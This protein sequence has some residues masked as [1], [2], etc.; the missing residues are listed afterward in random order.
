[1]FSFNKFKFKKTGQAPAAPSFG[2]KV[3]NVW[4]NPK[5]LEV[6]LI[7][8]G[9]RTE[10]DWGRNLSR[11]GLSL[12]I[13]LIFIVEI[14]WGLSWWEGKENSRADQ[15]NADL[16]KVDQEIKLVK[17]QADEFLTFKDKLTSLQPLLNNH[18]YWTNFFD[19]F[20]HHTL[21]S[22]VFSGFSGDTKGIYSLSAE[23][24]NYSDISYQVKAFLDAPETLKVEVGSGQSTQ[25][26]DKDGHIKPGVVVFS[27]S[28]QL[29]PSLFKK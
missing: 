8:E 9:A 19:W 18:I 28:L 23:A 22:V 3:G 4:E 25:G 17:T 16:K 24:K 6:N 1:M 12:V 15:L 5:V 10:F 14:Y 26:K 11:L 21:N 2:H 20:E 13:T 7:K 29:K 27:L